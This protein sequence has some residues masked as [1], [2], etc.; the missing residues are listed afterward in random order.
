[1]NTKNKNVL[2]LSLI[3]SLI[4]VI[5]AGFCYV[6]LLLIVNILILWIDYFYLKKKSV[7]RIHTSRKLQSMYKHMSWMIFALSI[8]LVGW[9]DIFRFKG[10]WGALFYFLEILGNVIF[11]LVFSFIPIKEK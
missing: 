5:T 8:V 6:S 9:L 4:L 11:I 2:F 10:D 7:T 3:N 1:M